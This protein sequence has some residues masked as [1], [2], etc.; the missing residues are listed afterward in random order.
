MKS[1]PPKECHRISSLAARIDLSGL[2]STLI[3]DDRDIGVNE[4]YSF[5]TYETV[6]LTESPFG[7]GLQ[8]TAR[9]S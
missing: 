6:V 4:L 5:R 8:D 2:I 3:L 9:V 1:N 7:D